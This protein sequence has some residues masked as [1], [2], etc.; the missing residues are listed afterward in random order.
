MWICLNCNSYVELDTHGRCAACGS[1]A[2][3]V[4]ERPQMTVEGLWLEGMFEKL[5]KLWRL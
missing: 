2:V 4:D 1:D 3:D 5:E